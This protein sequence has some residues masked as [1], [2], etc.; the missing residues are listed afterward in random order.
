MI[1]SCFDRFWTVRAPTIG[2]LAVAT[3]VMTAPLAA[4]AQATTELGTDASIQTTFGSGTNVTTVAFPSASIRAGFY[5]GPY[6]SFEPRVGV[7]STS[8]GG[9]TATVYAGSLSLLL[10]TSQARAGIGPYV[11]P[12]VGITGATGGGSSASQ[13][14][15][16]VGVGVTLPL[17]GELAT[18]LELNY[19]HAFSSSDFDSA[20][21]LG[22]HIG[23]SYFLR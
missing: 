12:F 11:R 9:S 13:T 18:R 20:N 2:A 19:A 15:A 4:H 7:L 14:E 22:A 6:L 21:A 16:G 1:R 5:A 8:G 10:H 23:L 17:A 3:L